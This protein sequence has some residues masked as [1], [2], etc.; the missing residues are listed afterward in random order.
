MTAA[1]SAGRSFSDRWDKE[2]GWKA[3]P[4]TRR[5]RRG[6]SSRRLVARTDLRIAGRASGPVD[7]LE[8]VKPRQAVVPGMLARVADVDD[9]DRL[10]AAVGEEVG[11]QT[12]CVEAGHRARRQAVRPH[13][14]DEVAGL[15]RAAE[16][17]GALP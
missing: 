17:A 9:Q 7:D 6:S 3:R 14:Q 10:P 11:V 5:I 4:R 8:M 12:P 13:G 15:H 2:D 1:R 16:L